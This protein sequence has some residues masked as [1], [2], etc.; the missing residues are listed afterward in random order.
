MYIFERTASTHPEFIKLVS[1]LDA[2]LKKRDG[3]EHEFYSQYNKVDEIKNVI[4]CYLDELA[5]GCGAFKP[6]DAKTVE[7]KR[8]FVLAAHR[9]KGVAEQ[10]FSHLEN[11]SGELN[12][13]RCILETGKNN[14]KR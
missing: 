8:M 11:W 2:D 14:Q 7:I 5:I 10:I 4:I 3:D 9:G 12:Y 6:Y 13:T 1:Q